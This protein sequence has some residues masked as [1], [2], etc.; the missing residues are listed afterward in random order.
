VILSLASDVMY[1][2]DNI[3]KAGLELGFAS[4]AGVCVIDPLDPLATSRD[5]LLDPGLRTVPLATH[6]AV[7]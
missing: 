2:T 4:E 7:T 3:P 6:F 1:I 5:G